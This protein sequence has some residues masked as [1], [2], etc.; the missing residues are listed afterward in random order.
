MLRKIIIDSILKQ[1][2]TDQAFENEALATF[3]EGEIAN[4][5]LNL[6]TEQDI[7]KLEKLRDEEIIDYLKTK[8]SGLEDMI[9]EEVEKAKEKFQIKKQP[10]V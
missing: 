8:V 1:S 10:V 2:D 6:L 9:T 5:L 4:K 3:I 7:Q